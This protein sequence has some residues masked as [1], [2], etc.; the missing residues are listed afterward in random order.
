MLQVLLQVVVEPDLENYEAVLSTEG[1]SG[2]GNAFINS[3]VIC[4]L[5]VAGNLIACSMAAYAFARLEFSGKTIWFALM[6]MTLNRATVKS[7]S[8]RCLKQRMQNLA[9]LR[10][11][12][13]V[14]YL[15]LCLHLQLLLLLQLVLFH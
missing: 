3:F 4:I 10:G 15:L 1:S 2:L 5:A 12:V 8:L 13:C 6:M 11:V 7:S 14:R 9:K